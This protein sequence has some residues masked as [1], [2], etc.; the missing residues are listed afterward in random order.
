MSTR[1]PA[2]TAAR[3]LVVEDEAAIRESVV[4]ALGDAGFRALGRGRRRRAS[5]SCSTA[6][7]P[8]SSCST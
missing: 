3:V 7:A 2:D 1:D 5:R 8:T 6:S 4:D